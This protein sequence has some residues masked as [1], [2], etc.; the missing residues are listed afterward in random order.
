M[1]LG[2]I[3]SQNVMGSNAGA[4]GA[5]HMVLCIQQRMKPHSNRTVMEKLWWQCTC[6]LIRAPVHAGNGAFT[7]H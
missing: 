4:L 1:L 6:V 2:V 3:N 7:G 5:A